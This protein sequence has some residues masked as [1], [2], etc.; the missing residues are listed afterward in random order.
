MT[1]VVPSLIDKQDGFEI[2]RD[3]IALILFIVT[4]LREKSEPEE[5]TEQDGEAT[6][7]VWLALLGVGLGVGLLVGGAWALVEGASNIARSI[8]VSDLVIG[9]TLVALGTS[10]PELAAAISAAR[11]REGDLILG[12]VVGS[13]IFNLL[14]VLGLT[15]SVQPIHVAQKVLDF[16][17]WVML[18]ISVLVMVA[19][20]SQRRLVRFE[21]GILL[22]YY[23]GYS[24]YLFWTGVSASA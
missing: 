11:R 22:V 21:G 2:V 1:Q 3:Q 6:R 19:L 13:N 14:C 16:D 9:L 4:Q 5:T 20:A 12:N 23:L 15:A 10:L 17:F 18:A 7:P 8:G 24:I